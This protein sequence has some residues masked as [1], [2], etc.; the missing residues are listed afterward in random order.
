MGAHFHREWAVSESCSRNDNEVSRRK[1][2]L[3]RISEKLNK[4]NENIIIEFI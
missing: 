4:R 1:R 3:S 2:A